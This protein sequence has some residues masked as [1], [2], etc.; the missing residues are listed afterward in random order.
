MQRRGARP[1]LSL[2]GFGSRE[3]DPTIGVNIAGEFRID[4]DTSSSVKARG[5]CG[6][7]RGAGLIAHGWHCDIGWR[8]SANAAHAVDRPAT[9]RSGPLLKSVK[10]SGPLGG[11]S[12]HDGATIP[13]GAGRG[14]VMN[15]TNVVKHYE[16]GSW[17]ADSPDMEGFTVVAPTLAALQE[18]VRGALAFHLDTDQSVLV[19]ESMAG[20]ESAGGV[21]WVPRSGGSSDQRI[22]T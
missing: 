5:Q 20:A 15:R 8:A 1:H 12:Y 7:A 2:C 19:A 4:G 10:E 17:W 14:D 3:E 18:A 13:P 22:E 21:T 6:L 9:I 16:D 11:F